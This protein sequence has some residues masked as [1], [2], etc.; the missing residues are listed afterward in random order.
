MINVTCNAI[1]VYCHELNFDWFSLL[2]DCTCDNRINLFDG[3][4]HGDIAQFTIH[5]TKA[6]HARCA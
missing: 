6:V 3:L 4:E 2:I 5:K 1:C